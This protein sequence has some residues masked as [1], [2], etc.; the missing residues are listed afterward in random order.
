MLWLFILL[1]S[2]AFFVYWLIT[3]PVDLNIDTEKA[4]A[5]FNWRRVGYIGIWYED[6]WWVSMRVFFYRKKIPFSRIKKRSKKN[7]NTI[8]SS[9]KRRLKTKRNIEKLIA[10]AKTLQ[11]MEWQLA[12]DMGEFS[13]NARLYP[14]NFLS[15][16]Y[17]HLNINFQ[18]KNFLIIKIKGWPW[19]MLYAFLK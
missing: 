13:R 5:V 7:N 15:C 9:D 2:L 19:K 11:V 4:I 6:E 14:L 3:S 8:K 18:N 12:I 1:S 16:T 17:D 10:V